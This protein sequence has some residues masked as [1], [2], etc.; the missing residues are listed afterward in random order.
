MRKFFILTGALV[1]GVL[2][3]LK[4]GGVKMRIL[5]NYGYK[6][7]G[8]TYSVTFE[9][10]GDVDQNQAPKVVD[11][12]FKLAK[13]AIQRQ[14]NPQPQ[15]DEEILKVKQES[16]NYNNNGNYP[17]TRKQLYLIKT[18][19]RKKHKKVNLPQSITKRQAS[20][21]IDYLQSL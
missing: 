6:T 20:E 1:T 14:I 9:T 18:L 5:A 13:E 21:L 10:M 3:T 11:E 12:L 15:E 19:A 7:N 4:E 17:A 8:E 2:V 16:N